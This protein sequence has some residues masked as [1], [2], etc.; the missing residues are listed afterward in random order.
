MKIVKT[1]LYRN[2]REEVKDTNN[3]PLSYAKSTN[4]ASN[5]AE[6]INPYYINIM[7]MKDKFLIPFCFLLFA[8]C[9]N[10][11]DI[12]KF[13][14]LEDKYDPSRPKEVSSISPLV[15]RVDDNFV[16]ET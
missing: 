3:L 7:K 15:G 1:P 4:F 5:K 10:S 14:D 2:K 11:E 12:K 16:L 9:S 8:A 6:I 13:P